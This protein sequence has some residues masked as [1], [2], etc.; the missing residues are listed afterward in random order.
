MPNAYD[1]QPWYNPERDG[2]LNEYFENMEHGTFPLFRGIDQYRMLWNLGYIEPN[3]TGLRMMFNV[4]RFD[5]HYLIIDKDTVVGCGK[6][7]GGLPGKHNIEEILGEDSPPFE[8]HYQR[9]Q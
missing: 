9:R 7:H 6:V 5:E 8:V 1:K 3:L 4:G 2:P